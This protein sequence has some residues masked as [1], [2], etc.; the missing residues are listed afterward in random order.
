MI[1]VKAITCDPEYVPEQ[2]MCHIVQQIIS[3]MTKGWTDITH[4]ERLFTPQTTI[5]ICILLP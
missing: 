5:N 3:D 2:T 4:P 1:T